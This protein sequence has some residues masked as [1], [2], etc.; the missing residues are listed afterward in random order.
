MCPNTNTETLK[1]GITLASCLRGTKGFPTRISHSEAGY[2]SKYCQLETRIPLTG[3]RL[4]YRG[5]V[6]VI[7]APATT[8]PVGL[9]T[10]HRSFSER[11]AIFPGVA[12]PN[13]SL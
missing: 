7:T 3:S 6:P 4:Y 13:A 12:A 9:F 10:G 8:W 5:D 1:D 2:L 11:P